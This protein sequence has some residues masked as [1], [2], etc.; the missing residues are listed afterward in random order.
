M[1]IMLKKK[2]IINFIMTTK[3]TFIFP[4]LL[5]III[6][7][8]LSTGFV[9]ADV[10]GI[11]VIKPNGGEYWSGTQDITWTATG[12]D[13]DTVDIAYTKG[14]AWTT[15][16]S[17]APYNFPY[18]WD[19]STVTDG[20]NY[21]IRVKDTNSNVNDVSINIFTIDNTNPII[22]IDTVTTL[23]NVNTQTITGTITETNINTIVVNGVGATISGSTYTAN[24]PLLEGSNT[25]TATATD[26]AGN[27]GTATDSINLDTGVPTI[28]SVSPADGSYVNNNKPT[29]SAT[30]G[31]DNS[32]IDTSSVT[33]SVNG[34][35]VT[36]SESITTTSVSYTPGSALS[37]GNISVVITAND[38]AGNSAVTSSTSFIVD[39]TAPDATTILIAS[40]DVVTKDSTPALALTL[41]GTTPD[42]MRFSCDNTNWNNWVAW[43][44]TYDL[45]NINSGSNG[46]TI[47]D[48]EKTVYVQVK[49]TAGNIQATINS[50]SI[51]YDSDNTLTVASSG[52][53]F[54]LIQDA[55]DVATA[56]D[57]INVGA[58]DYTEQ[59]TI[60]KSLNLIGAGESTTTIIAPATGR[61]TVSQ[62]NAGYSDIVWDYVV[63]AYP[64]SGTIDVKI[65]GFTID[66]NGQDAT[67][68]QNFAAVFLRDVGNGID[69]GLYSCTI[70]NFGSYG[71][72][73]N[74]W[75]GTYG[76]WM[77]NYGT[78][79]Y[80]T[81][82]LIINGNDINDYTVSGV[83]ANGADIEVVVTNNDLDGTYSDYA[84]L[85][86]RD[87]IGTISGNNIHD[88]YGVIE[89]MGI[90]LFDAGLVSIDNSISTN[91]ISDNYIGLFLKGTNGATIA[92][93]T[94]TDNTFRSIV[95]Q[96]DSD[97]NIV[98]GNT[99]TMGGA[100]VGAGIVIGSDS[101]GNIIGGDIAEDGNSITIPTSGSDVLYAI[102]MNEADTGAVTIKNN[103]I[104]G[105]QRS[106]QFDGGPGHS[107]L[108]TISDNIMTGPLFGGIISSCFGDFIVSG[109][110]ITNSDRPMEFWQ[111]GNGD[112]RITGNTINGT[113]YDTVNIGS[114]ALLSSFTDNVFRNIEGKTALAYRLSGDITVGINYWGVPSD[115]ESKIVHKVDDSNYGTVDYTPWAYNS[116]MDVDETAP[117]VVLSDDSDDI[118]RD[119]NTVVITATFTEDGSGIDETTV[120]KIT[121]GG[122]VTNANMTKTSNLVW[123]YTWGV[124]A[125]NDGNV[126]VSI[127]AIDVAGNVNAVATGETSYTID[128]T[129]PTIVI[130]NP[131]T[132]P[133]QSKTITA[134]SGETLTMSLDSEGVCNSGLTFITYASTTFSSESNNG[135][136]V[137]Y[138]AVDTAGNEKYELSNVI[139][140]IDTTAPTITITNPNTD[141]AQSKMITASVGEG[142]LTMFIN[143]IGVDTCDDSLTFV[144]YSSTTFSSEAD[145]GKKVCYK[146]EDSL[147]NIDYSLSDVIGGIDTTAPT[148]SITAPLSG[149]EIKSSYAVTFTDDEL[150]AAQCSIDNS[151][152]VSCTSGVTTLGDITGFNG[153]G[154][155]TFT[156]YLK[157]TDTAGNV[158]T[159]SESGVIKDTT[160]PTVVL[161]NDDADN[162]VGD[163]DTVIIT[164][165]FTEANTL[166]ESPAPTISIGNL[167]TDATMIRTNNLVWTYS[168]N[169]P[170][171]NDGAQAISVSATDVAGNSNNA[172][173]GVTS[174]TIDNTAP[175]INGVTQITKKQV[176]QSME[177]SAT[178]TDSGSGIKTNNVIL[179][180]NN[181]TDNTLTMTANGDVYTQTIPSQS[182]NV[183]ITYY[184]T[185]DD[186]VDNSAT[187]STYTITVH[188][189]IWDLTSEWNLVSVPKVLATEDK[190]TLLGNTVWYYDATDS[191]EPWKTPITIN[192]GIGYWVDDSALTSLGLDYADNADDSDGGQG[193][194][195]LLIINQGWNLIGLMNTTSMTVEDAF[196]GVSGEWVPN[197]YYVIK[198]NE[199]TEEFEELSKDNNMNSGEGY[200]V[201]RY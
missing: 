7:G 200:W 19:T 154:E 79:I 84:G 171:G 85:Y 60:D 116:N 92:G 100:D 95:I 138:K 55:I 101:G 118:V 105:G 180:Y 4:S 157:D 29:I 102:L 17:L 40:G 22:T 64:S 174:L 132:N 195:N 98:K 26:L 54:T 165:T 90:Y 194:P 73:P 15:I 25:I 86:L 78:I 123:T 133:A 82:D 117:T 8:V 191:G 83:S 61:S 63:A 74:Y 51:I 3:K 179:H 111:S 197:I 58:G 12:Y 76:T 184:I 20:N 172:A 109:N 198:Y 93:N 152:W 186:N 164:A 177:I 153:L 196:T 113:T 131:N 13:G 16:V 166:D 89:N 48:G 6:V 115:I 143:A 75:S 46:C 1:I 107:G 170:A 189:L 30:L 120:P 81:S 159:D 142:T 68:D 41:T 33:I 129:A 28:T 137:C 104:I 139:V 136:T 156:L 62:P 128:N 145:N 34:V 146:S 77:G 5:I 161:S 134:T 45:F 66:A 71:S 108:N 49:D 167:I 193:Q 182:D 96:Q 9:V 149:T 155:G 112:L 21:Q 32:G 160:N 18:S 163:A 127:T 53:D 119:A 201:Y 88:H 65:Q 183:T 144:A 158:G 140:G 59:I 141:P 50:D 175:T 122:V 23:T 185:A 42:Y 69:D 39:T 87:G 36:S 188:D 11:D 151:V 190:S 168:W 52:A 126:D 187:S 181:G 121:I 24:V 130:T 106:I 14:I 97:N 103:E 91:T 124:P 57:I 80:G 99:I 10:T 70:Q 178:V 67:A 35:D 125:G 173:T 37:E 148:V 162:L 47:G 176:G 192:P 56:G 43:A 169:I 38:L 94:F 2:L 44:T 31:D 114:A 150:T 27:T 72:S 110:T 135:E 147:G 199:G